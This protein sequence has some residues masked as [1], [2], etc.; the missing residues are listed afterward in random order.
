MS[1]PVGDVDVQAEK[2]NVGPTV[3]HNK[4]REESDFDETVPL[5]DGPE[6]KVLEYN[7]ANSDAFEKIQIAPTI[8]YGGNNV[9]SEFKA[10]KT[11]TG[12]NRKMPNLG[13]TAAYNVLENV[14]RCG[15]N[16]EIIA[17]TVAFSDG[18]GAPPKLDA[19]DLEHE[20]KTFFAAT[21][22]YD[23]TGDRNRSLDATVAYDANSGERLIDPAVA[24]EGGSEQ[25]G[26]RESG[27]FDPTIPIDQTHGNVAKR[28]PVVASI[29]ER[30]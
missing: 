24:S 2:S 20:G 8:A 5:D 14:D 26:L 29:F 4:S 17:P 6:K 28:E 1:L 7:N 27:G 13:A 30:R 11:E 9:G 16:E 19:K 25:H 15:K 21:V 10:R 23:T 3:A 18:N 12:A 22:A